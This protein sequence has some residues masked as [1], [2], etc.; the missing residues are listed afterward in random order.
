MQTLVTST[1]VLW[2]EGLDIESQLYGTWVEKV[3]EIRAKIA[4]FFRE[5]FTED[6]WDRPH[7]DGII[8]LVLLPEESSSLSHLSLSHLRWLIVWLLIAMVIRV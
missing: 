2:L 6:D 8:F 5:Q 1:L 4:R 3:H 7:L